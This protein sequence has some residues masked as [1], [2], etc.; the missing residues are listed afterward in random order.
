MPTNNKKSYVVIDAGGQRFEVEAVAVSDTSETGQ[1]IV[2][3]YEDAAKEKPCGSFSAPTS[4]GP[5]PS[6]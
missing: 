5:A 3:F 1:R 4:W 2:T 6:A